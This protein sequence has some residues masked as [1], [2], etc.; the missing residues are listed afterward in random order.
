LTAASI[1][2]KIM[3]PPPSFLAQVGK[4]AIRAGL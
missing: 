1:T 4:A 3:L 2:V